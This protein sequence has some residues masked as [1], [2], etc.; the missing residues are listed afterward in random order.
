METSETFCTSTGSLQRTS[1]QPMNAPPLNAPSISLG[2]PEKNNEMRLYFLN[3]FKMTF[4][5]YDEDI[6]HFLLNS[7]L[8]YSWRMVS[9]FYKFLEVFWIFDIF[10][11]SFVSGGM[12]S[13]VQDN[14]T[15]I[16]IYW[17]VR[18]TRRQEIINGQLWPKN[19]LCGP[20]VA[21]KGSAFLF[22]VIFN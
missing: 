13:L 1:G 21:N 12:L 17:C 2:F 22:L 16:Q 14:T 8:C 19:T 4:R 9:R 6:Y 3:D 11:M 7:A 10:L 18:P 15:R 20:A 5:E